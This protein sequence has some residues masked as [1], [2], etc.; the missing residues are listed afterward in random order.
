MRRIAAG[1]LV[2][3][4]ALPALRAEDKA[5][6]G[7]ASPK[8]QYEALVKQ[9][10][11]GMQS[12]M[13][14]F[15]A[16]K[17]EEAQ[18]KLIRKYE[19]SLDAFAPKFVELAQKHPADPVAVDA[20]VWVVN[21]ARGHAGDEA[22]PRARTLALLAQDHLTD[23]KVLALTSSMA[24]HSDPASEAFLRTVMEK[25]PNKQ[26][27][28]RACL[29]LGLVLHSR[30]TARDRLQDDTE[31]MDK[32]TVAW[33]KSLDPDKLRKE[34]E[35]VLERAAD[36]YGDVTT[37][38]KKTVRERA[39]GQLFE[40]RSLAVGKEVPDIEGSDQDGKSFKLSEYRGK[41]VLLDFWGNW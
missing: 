38:S 17:G 16:A 37:P 34:A 39:N 2:L 25:G 40:L 10:E 9:Y 30:L 7:P 24:G 26:A 41:V 4:L 23:A 8:A 31:G 11:D 1:V 33:L 20:L 32:Q 19:A 3:V 29:A 12:L 36:R 18:R 15:Q 22:D 27:Q 21:N 5:K 28:G 14:E 6:A 13:K 35:E